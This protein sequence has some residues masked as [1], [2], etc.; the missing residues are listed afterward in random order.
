M[1][2]TPN[3]SSQ[4]RGVLAILAAQ[5][6]V[7][8]HGYEISRLTGL[9]SGTLYPLLRRLNEQALLDA[10]WVLS[11][12]PGRPPRHIYRLTRRGLSLARSLS[13]SFKPF[14]PTRPA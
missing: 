6:G 10:T 11:P 2:R 7:W 8:R 1:A 3:V 13:V 14:D 12:Q 5:S 9:K 4:T